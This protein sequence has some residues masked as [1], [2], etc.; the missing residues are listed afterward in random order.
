VLYR[1]SIDFNCSGVSS[2]ASST[3][4]VGSVFHRGPLQSSIFETQRQ[5]LIWMIWEIQVPERGCELLANRH[6]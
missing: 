2:L 6:A 1:G 5:G 4:Q 3:S